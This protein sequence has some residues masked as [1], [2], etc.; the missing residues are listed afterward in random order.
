VKVGDTTLKRRQQLLRAHRR[1][2]EEMVDYLAGSLELIDF[3][4]NFYETWLATGV[5]PKAT[6]PRKKLQREGSPI[7]IAL[8]QQQ[9]KRR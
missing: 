3:K 7:T 2:L 1:R 4:I 8:P 6:S 9:L 5:E